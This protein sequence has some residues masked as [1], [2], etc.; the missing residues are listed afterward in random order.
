V[1]DPQIESIAFRHAL[2]KSERLRIYI[3][4]ATVATAF[5]LRTGRSV[6][7]GGHDNLSEWLV[8]SVLLAGLAAFELV[9]LCGVNRAIQKDQEVPNAAWPIS[10]IL[11]TS[12]PALSVAF[13]P[14]ALID[15]VYRPLANPAGLVF[16]L[17]IILSTLRLNPKLCRL[18][19]F[20]AAIGYLAAAAHLGWKPAISGGTSLL[21]PERAVFSYAITFVVAGFVSGMVAAEIRKQVDAALREAKAQ[22]QVDRLEH[23]LELARSIQRSLLPSTMP[24]IVGFQIAGWNQPADH[25]GGD[26][27]DWQLLPDGTVVLAVADVT[28]HGIGPALLAAV[29]R[30][31]ARTI[32]GLNNG[33]MRAME[34]I[35]AALAVDVGEGRFVTFVAAICSPENACVQLLSAGHGPLFLYL[36]REDRFDQ[37][38]AQGL[39]FG[40]ISTLITEP[41]RTLE[42]RPGDLL[43]L[44][45]DGF[46][47][48][49]NPQGESFGTHRLE[50]A[51]R[52]SKDKVPQELISDLYQAVVD[53]SGGRKQQDDLTAVII[54]R[55]SGSSS[56]RPA[57]ESASCGSGRIMA[58]N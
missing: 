23:D 42:L 55:T 15:P 29:C 14:G 51:I 54:K 50:E 56:G 40:V 33:L 36:S 9:M 49:E 16:F 6:I 31:Y 11:E 7:V 45:T 25:T 12:F 22:R 58:V 30:A 52:K 24:E 20:S 35:N 27:Y 32:F 57:L 34:Q 48:W 37:M 10:I 26:Y 1:S 19:G 44:A 39:P 41:P 53:F 4:L 21:S 3:V 17:F 5:L 13:L 47:E 43:V 28:G 46:F 18:S 38:G 8:A 2:L